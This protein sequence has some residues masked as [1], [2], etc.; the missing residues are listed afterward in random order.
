[1]V[2]QSQRLKEASSRIAEKKLRPKRNA[3]TLIAIL[4]LGTRNQYPYAARR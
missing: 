1:M 4:V 3:Q 2:K